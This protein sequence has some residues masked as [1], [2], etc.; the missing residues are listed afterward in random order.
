MSKGFLNIFYKIK[1][2][3]Q[4]SKNHVEILELKRTN[5]TFYP[6]YR[7]FVGMLHNR[8]FRQ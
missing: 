4:N 5:Q 7:R 1:I 3:L 8:A 2:F 6:F